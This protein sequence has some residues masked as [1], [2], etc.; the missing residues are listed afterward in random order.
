MKLTFSKRKYMSELN[1]IFFIKDSL[2][3]T[4]NHL[5]FFNNNIKYL[6]F[7]SISFVHYNKDINI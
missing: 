1:E 3:P 7:K 4:G 6:S 5:I 2:I